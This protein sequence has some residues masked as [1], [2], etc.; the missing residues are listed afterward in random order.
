MHARVVVGVGKG[1]LFREVSSVQRCPYREVPL[2]LP[3]RAA[4]LP[5]VIC[6]RRQLLSELV[7]G[8]SV[9][10]RTWLT[11]ANTMWLPAY[12]TEPRVF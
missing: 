8:V 9:R 3:A 10:I 1:V 4:F 12:Q 5:Y 7:T 11:C 6:T 2:Y